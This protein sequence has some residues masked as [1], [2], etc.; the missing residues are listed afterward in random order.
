VIL[1]P[2]G[3]LTLDATTRAVDIV[4]ACLLLVPALPV[5]VVLAPLLRFSGDGEILFR[6]RRIGRGG[7]PFQLLK[8]ATMVKGSAGIGSGEITLPDDPRLRRFG[9]FLRKTKL[10]EIPQLFNIFAGDLSLVGPRPQTQRY[11]DAFPPASRAVVASVRPGLTGVGSILFRDEER[12][13]ARVDD[14]I[15]FDL[16]VITPYKG[17]VES[18]YVA[19]RSIGL[20]LELIVRTALVVLMPR[21]GFH[22]AL[23]RRLPAPPDALAALL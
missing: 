23:L 11:F 1:S 7:R 8:F 16:S 18:W 19:H 9:R 10:N 2:P 6:Q 14:P 5:F 17:E 12:L 3:G 4:V 21:A 20:Y 15:A 13:L 22:Q